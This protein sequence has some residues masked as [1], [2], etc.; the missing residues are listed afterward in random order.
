MM[1]PKKGRGPNTGHVVTKGALGWI[2]PIC[3]QGVSPWVDVCPCRKE[4][5]FKSV[6]SDSTLQQRPVPYITE[7]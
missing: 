1:K 4:P 6:P 7:R 3:D 2:C 5:E